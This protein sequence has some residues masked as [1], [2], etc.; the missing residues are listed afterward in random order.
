[1]TRARKEDPGELLDRDGLINGE[2]VGEMEAPV[3]LG[4]Q[5]SEYPEQLQEYIFNLYAPPV[6][7]MVDS[8][9]DRFDGGKDALDSFHEYAS[10]TFRNIVSDMMRTT[11]FIYY[12]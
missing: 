6:D 7:S 3:D 9:R 1:V 11:V 4:E 5:Y 12:R 10:D 8:L 2:L